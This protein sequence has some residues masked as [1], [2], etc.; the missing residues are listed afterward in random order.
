[1]KKRFSI[2]VREYQSD[3]DIELMQLDNNPEP[4][5]TQLRD[6][7]LNFGKGRKHKQYNWVRVVDN[8]QP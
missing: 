6:K 2:W 7:T 3:H 5:A 8:A 1:M 4:I